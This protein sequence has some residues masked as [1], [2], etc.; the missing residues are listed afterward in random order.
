MHRAV[1]GGENWSLHFLPSL[2]P[3]DERS[4]GEC[5]SPVRWLE[6]RDGRGC[7]TGAQKLINHTWFPHPF[8]NQ[9]LCQHCLQ[10]HYQQPSTGEK[11]GL[12]HFP[13]RPKLNESS[14]APVTYG[15]PYAPAAGRAASL[16]YATCQTGASSGAQLCDRTRGWVL[17]CSRPRLLGHKVSGSHTSHCVHWAV[18]GKT[19]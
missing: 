11:P 10:A 2:L 8:W 1:S 18:L 12:Q 5:D 3:S 14:W 15:C 13:S 4:P 19:S 7:R 9:M 17:Q 16:W 6:A